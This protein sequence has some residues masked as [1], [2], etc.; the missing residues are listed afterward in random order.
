MGGRAHLAAER[1]GYSDAYSASFSLMENPAIIKRIQVTLIKGLAEGA[2][3]S[4][5]YLKNVARGE[6]TANPQR[7]KAATFLME[8]A[9]IKLTS[10]AD[11]GASPLHEMSAT[12]L[13]DIKRQIVEEL[14]QTRE[15]T[16][17]ISARVL[18]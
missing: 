4:A 7:V 10:I 6:D 18:E 5:Q 8:Q 17:L 15:D 13:A 2:A 3:A 1:A 11:D 9:G 12:E 14:E 16:E